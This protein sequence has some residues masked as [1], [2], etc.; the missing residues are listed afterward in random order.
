MNKVTVDLNMVG[1]LMKGKISSNK[2]GH[3]V[4]T[5][6]WH[7]HQSHDTQVL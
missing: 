7:R 1:T 6:Q 4:I 2:D 3:L 5:M